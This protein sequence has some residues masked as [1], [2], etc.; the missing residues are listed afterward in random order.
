MTVRQINHQIRI[1]R[2]CVYINPPGQDVSISGNKLLVSD[3]PEHRTGWL[4]S[5][6]VLKRLA[7]DR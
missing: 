3:Q 7:K 6:F 5:G 4:S 1:E 2:D